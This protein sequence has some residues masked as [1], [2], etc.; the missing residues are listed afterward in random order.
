MSQLLD[1]VITVSSVKYDDEDKPYA[2][3]RVYRFDFTEEGWKD[4]QIYINTNAVEGGPMR[5]FASKG[6]DQE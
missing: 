2:I 5:N 4:A 1:V 6:G 3:T